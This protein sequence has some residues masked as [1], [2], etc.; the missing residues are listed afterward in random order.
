MYKIVEFNS[1]DAKLKGRF[2]KPHT[3]SKVPIVIMA[4]GYSATLE[5]M[6]ADKYAE[7][8]YHSGYAV[9][10]YD[11][12]NFGISGGQ[13][14]Q[15]INEWTQARGYRDAI[16]YAVTLPG[17]DSSKIIL[18]GDSMSAREIIVVAAIDHRVKGIIGQVPAF[19]DELP[20]QDKDGKLFNSIKETFLKGNVEGTEETTIGPLPVV[21]FSQL[22]IPSMLKE[23]TA[24]RWFMEYGC[25]YNT[26]WINEVT[27][28]VADVPVKL[29]AVICAPHI[30][31]ALLLVV[32]KDDEMEGANSDISRYLYK[33][34]PEPKKMVEVDG[35]HFGIIHYPSQL[36]DKASAEQV[37]FLNAYFK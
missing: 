23:L 33:I 30:K 27:H 22:S 25:R 32:A 8:F 15:Q 29:N 5:G 13:P 7:K 12:R 19:G 1:E 17:I 2:Y 21:S 35:G 28:V 9:L 31:A 36:F 10:L 3:T 6:C 24:F 18:W 11:H 34:A 37:D 14:R 26:K 16:D 4:H 20:P